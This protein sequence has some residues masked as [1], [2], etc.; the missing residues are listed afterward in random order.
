MNRSQELLNENRP[1]AYWLDQSGESKEGPGGTRLYRV[2]LVFEN[3]SGHF[4]TGGSIE[5]I[6]WF[7]NQET[8]AAQNEKRG[9]NEERVHEITSSSI[10]HHT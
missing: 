3:E 1:Y 5:V 4:P 10:F 8:C 2:S 9:L 6:P 7:W